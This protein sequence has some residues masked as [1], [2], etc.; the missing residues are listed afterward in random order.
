M[1]RC[2]A[3][4]QSPTCIHLRDP[5]GIRFKF[6]MAF[7]ANPRKYCM[8]FT[9]RRLNDRTGSSLTVQAVTHAQGWARIAR[10]TGTRL[11]ESS[12]DLH[13]E[14]TNTKSAPSACHLK[15]GDFSIF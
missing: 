4:S 13:R 11:I 12:S 15:I 3:R 2:F 5:V 14:L 7:K 10:V 1:I 8:S 6:S 9:I